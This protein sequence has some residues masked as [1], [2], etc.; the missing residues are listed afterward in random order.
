MV[1]GSSG[2]KICAAN[3]SA[4][5]STS[6]PVPS[7]AA[8]C[9]ATSSAST[10][11]TFIGSWSE[12]PKSATAAQPA[13]SRRPASRST[14]IPP[15]SDIGKMLVDGSLDATVLYIPHFVSGP[16]LVDRSSARL[17]DVTQP[18][19]A[20]PRAEARRYYEKTGIYPINHCVV[21]RRTLFEREPWIARSIYDAFVA[22]KADAAR[23]RRSL[24][25]PAL[26]TGLLSDAAGTSIEDDV[27]AYGADAARVTLE[28]I[29]RY[30]YEQGLTARRLETR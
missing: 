22:A 29:M 13:S 4:F 14:Y 19:F 27:M 9:S 3:A 18:L 8:A 15:S 16:N 23:R 7:G 6:R 11:A 20:N 30:L 24:L 25:E 1:P 21:V 26:A 10:P 5:P 17:D 2:R 28:T 12:R